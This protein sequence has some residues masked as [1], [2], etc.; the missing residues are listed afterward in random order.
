MQQS[1]C[2]KRWR[3]DLRTVQWDCCD[4]SRVQAQHKA[5]QNELV[6]RQRHDVLIS[7]RA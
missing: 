4:T 7:L 1:G 6:V 3:S 5:L 2:K